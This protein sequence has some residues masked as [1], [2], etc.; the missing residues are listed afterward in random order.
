VPE[1]YN[2]FVTFHQSYAYEEFIEGIR[3]NLESP[4]KLTYILQ[5]GAFKELALRAKK[6][7]N[8][9]YYLV[10]DEINRGNISKI[11]GELITLI[12]KDK[13]LNQNNQKQESTIKVELPYSKEL[14]EVPSN[15]YIIGTMNTADKSIALVD[16]A[17]RRRFGFMEFIPNPD[18]L[19]PIDMKGFEVNLPR[20]LRS[21]N[22]KIEI[23]LDRDHRIGH[24]YLMNLDTD[25]N[26][27]F[28]DD[29]NVIYDNLYFA[30]YHEFVPLIQEYFYNDWEKIQTVLGD[31]V[32][33]KITYSSAQDIVQSANQ[34]VFSIKELYGEEFLE[35]FIKLGERSST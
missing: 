14:F 26:G 23:L 24:S 3:P 30:F 10:I 8:N 11:F 19:K 1:K 34:G 7:P 16:V 25:K 27:E 6:D 28:T 22:E 20:F 18:L 13:R 5:D 35:N 33:T 2:K 4:E 29:E 12:E 15:L 21:I 32:E 31:F 9:S 17:L